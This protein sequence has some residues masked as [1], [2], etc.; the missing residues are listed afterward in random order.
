MTYLLSTTRPVGTTPVDLPL[1]GYGA[2]ALGNLYRAIGDEVALA[3]IDTAR[4]AG[5]TYLDTAPHYGQGLSER[6]IGLSDWRGKIST[7]VGRRLEAIA[8]PAAGFMRHGFVD[9]DAFEPVFDYTYDGVM[10]A[11]KDSLLRLGRDRVD[12]LLAHDLGRETHGAD[13]GRHLRDFLDGGYKAMRSLKDGGLVG[14]IG[15]GV[16]E[17]QV[18]A[19]VLPYTDLDVFLL[20]GRYTLLEQTA[21]DSFLPECQR[22]N[23]S[24]IVGGPYN[25]GI[26]IEGIK[27]GGVTHY[28]YEPAPADIIRRVAG[29][30]SICADHRIPLAAAALQFPLA[31][32]TVTCVIPGM[33][34]SEQVISNVDLFSMKIPSSLWSD[35]K[36]AGLLHPSAPLPQA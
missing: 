24:I 25:S 29:L 10:R 6:R 3:A 15:L 19:D 2:G 27:P 4:Q 21:L 9:G 30:Q 1:L 36:A 8:P 33:A 17:W 7:K 35:L 5:I 18:C 11:F 26:L 22:R 32:P 16:N 14:A 31:H 13:H 12:V 28:N 20:A 23:I 34:S